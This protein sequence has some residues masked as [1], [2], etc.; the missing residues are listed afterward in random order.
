MTNLPLIHFIP[1]SKYLPI[2]FSAMFIIG[3]ADTH[4]VTLNAP[5]EQLHNLHDY[6]SDGVIKVRDKCAE[7]IFGASID[8]YGCGI[9]STK[10]TAFEVD[11]KFANN[12]AVIPSS[13]YAEIEKLAKIL[14]EHQ[15]VHELIEGHSS[16]VGSALF[17]KA[18][19][20]ERAKAVAYVLINDFNIDKNRISSIGYGSERLKETENS[21]YAHAENRRIIADLLYTQNVDELKWTIYT[22][23]EVN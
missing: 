10:I 9:K 1:R 19:S 4:I 20:D 15:E 18:L 6:D 17:N 13:A 23:D 7:T 2:L 8:N 14:D 12:S 21:E 11:I 3:C 5:V 22:V 16:K